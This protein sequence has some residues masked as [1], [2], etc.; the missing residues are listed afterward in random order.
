MSEWDEIRG[1]A[2]LRLADVLAALGIRERP[3]GGRIIMCSPV[4]EDHHPSFSICTEGP[5]AGCFIDFAGYAQGDIFHL[6]AYLKGWSAGNDGKGHV[7]AKKWLADF[8]GYRRLSES[9]RHALNERAT[10]RAAQGRARAK[11][12]DASY[13][14]GADKIWN[15]SELST[16]APRPRSTC[17]K[18]ERSIPMISPETCAVTSV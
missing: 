6:V 2:Q 8:L 12:R 17:G 15:E 7:E 16:A 5:R 9:E 3:R 13:R 18:S 10:V 1:L 4:R 14:R 11:A